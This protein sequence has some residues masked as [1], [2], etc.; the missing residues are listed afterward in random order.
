[1]GQGSIIGYDLSE[2]GCQISYYNEAQH[3]P[4]TVKNE[5]GE[6]QIPLVIGC[7]NDAWYIGEEARSHAKHKD[8]AM[9]TDLLAKSMHGAKI[10]LGRRT[11]DA[12]WLL[13]KFIRLTTS[14]V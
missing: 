1:M 13:A 3:E 12:V 8:G 5:S 4:E 7:K 9:A 10:H 2:E 6:Y 11:Y 14:A